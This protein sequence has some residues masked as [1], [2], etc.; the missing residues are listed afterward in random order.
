MV[1]EPFH[2]VVSRGKIACAEIDLVNKTK[3]VNT[4]PKNM[5]KAFNMVYHTEKIL[6]IF[7]IISKKIPFLS[8][9]HDKI[10]LSE[11]VSY[12]AISLMVIL[13]KLMHVDF[14]IGLKS[15]DHSIECKFG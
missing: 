4:V 3:Q 1:L 9:M 10:T 6:N 13:R 2:K 5:V 14:S 8:H 7:Y 12:M 15:A 11:Y